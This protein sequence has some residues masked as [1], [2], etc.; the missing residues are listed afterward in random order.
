MKKI[1][2]ITS[3]KELMEMGMS[4]GA[5]VGHARH[6]S[7]KRHKQPSTSAS[8]GQGQANHFKPKGKDMRQDMQ[9][10]QLGPT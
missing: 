2:E 4:G 7:P 10:R 9:K 8:S 6:P 1:I 5:V 3:I